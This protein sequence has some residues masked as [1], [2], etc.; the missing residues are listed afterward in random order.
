MGVYCD[1]LAERGLTAPLSTYGAWR[2]RR[3]CELGRY[4]EAERLARESRELGDEDDPITQAYWRQVAALVHASRGEHAE[5]ERLARE[6]VARTEMTDSP[7][8]Q[9]D[10]LSDLGDVLEVAGRLD[11]ATDTFR[12]ALGCYERKRIVPLVR[13]V[14]KRLDALER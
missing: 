1:W 11:E 12:D 8:A 3:L 6:A 13:Q 5:A 7:K 2:G 4:D 10:A 9:G 14:R